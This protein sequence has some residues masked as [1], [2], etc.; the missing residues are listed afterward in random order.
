MI[1]PCV[2][3]VVLCGLLVLVLCLFVG[4]IIYFWLV[5]CVCVYAMCAVC[6]GCDNG[7]YYPCYCL[8]ACCLFCFLI[9]VIVFCFIYVLKYL[10]FF[11]YTFNIV[12]FS[13]CGLR[14][15]GFKKRKNNSI[16]HKREWNEMLKS[17]QTH[18]KHTTK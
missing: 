3:I 13:C 16:K 15:H 10:F 2:V 14:K 1:I 6:M 18:N 8:C 11:D 7:C 17:L 5:L 9:V 12:N 4:V